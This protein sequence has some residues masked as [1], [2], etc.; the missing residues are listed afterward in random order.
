M[1]AQLIQQML[2][3]LAEPVVAESAARFFKKEHAKDI[4]FA[5]GSTAALFLPFLPIWGA[6][7]PIHRTL[8]FGS[9]ERILLP[10]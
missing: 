6:C 4:L 5:S 3:T 8:V 9:F 2:R 1:N 10:G 7:L